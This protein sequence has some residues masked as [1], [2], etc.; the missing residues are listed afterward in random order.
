MHQVDEDCSGE[1][2][3]CEFVRCIEKNKMSSQLNADET[4]TVDAFVALGGN[5]RPAL[6]AWVQAWPGHC[7]DIPLHVMHVMHAGWMPGEQG[8]VDRASIVVLPARNTML[9]VAAAAALAPGLAC[10]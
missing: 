9:L 7:H 10:G 6:L 2:E 8:Q 4:D 1:V 5:V 3:F